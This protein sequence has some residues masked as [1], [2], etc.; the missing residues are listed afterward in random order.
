MDL[1]AAAAVHEDHDGQ[2]VHRR[3][4]QQLGHG[5][6]CQPRAMAGDQTE[7]LLALHAEPAQQVEEFMRVL[8]ASQAALRPARR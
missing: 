3:I 8:K 7:G 4:A 2:P 5:L 6:G 1:D